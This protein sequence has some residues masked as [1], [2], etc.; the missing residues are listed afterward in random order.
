MISRLTLEQVV[1]LWDVIKYA[2]DVS[3]PPT[4]SRERFRINKILDSI[5][6]GKM[7]CWAVYERDEENKVISGHAVILT[8]ITVDECSG[9]RALL[10]YA[11]ARL[12]ERAPEE[13]WYEGLSALRKYAVANSCQSLIAQ[14]NVEFV[15]DKLVEAGGEE[16][17]LMIVPIT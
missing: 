2:I 8:V 11:L 1:D 12:S 17:S 4:A 10:V 5:L 13:L 7:D 14:T 9:A 15:R 6:C 16:Y 3:L